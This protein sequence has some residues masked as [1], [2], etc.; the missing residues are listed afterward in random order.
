M[1]DSTLISRRQEIRAQLEQ[2]P[3]HSAAHTALQAIYDQS[4]EII[5]Q[6]ARTAW[7]RGLTTAGK[8]TATAPLLAVEM[9]LA[10]ADTLN[11]ALET[12]LWLL[13]DQLIA[14]ERELPA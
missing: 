3:P 7:T 10:C 5:S 14:A 4:T 13:R 1:D 12:N 6:R 2:L 8:T 11:N 9:L